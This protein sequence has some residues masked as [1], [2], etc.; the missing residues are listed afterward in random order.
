MIRRQAILPA[1]PVD[2]LRVMSDPHDVAAIAAAND[3]QPIALTDE[4]V[5]AILAFLDAL[6]DPDSL[7]GRLGVPDSVPSGLPVPN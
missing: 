4:E 7:A 5:S 2:D 3:L 6:T 1:L